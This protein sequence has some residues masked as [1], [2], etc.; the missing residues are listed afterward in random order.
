ME[1]PVL[2]RNRRQQAQRTD[3]PDKL[4]RD[5]PG[6]PLTRAEDPRDASG[7]AS[8]GWDLWG[9][10]AELQQRMG[11]LIGDVIGGSDGQAPWPAPWPATGW[12]PAADVEE[13]PDAYLVEI[14]LP[15]VKGED[16][17][18][19][20]SPGELVVTGE[21]KERQRVGLLRTRTRRTG[22]FDYRVLLPADIDPEQVSAA[23]SDGVLTVR[24]PKTEQ[25]KRRK[26]TIDS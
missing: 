2:R 9:E 13:T 5:H 23:L 16:V 15:A 20:V 11:R 14:E 4:R 26:I 6:G 21:I 8:G 7:G 25:A 19:E 22:R 17:S 24:V 12:R 3:D 10:L 18:V 1:L